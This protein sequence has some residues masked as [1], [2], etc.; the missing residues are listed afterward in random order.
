[1]TT[2]FNQHQLSL[3]QAA[4]FL[5]GGKAIFTIKSEVTGKHFTYKITRNKRADNEMYFVSLMTG[6]SNE[7]NYTFFATIFG[8]DNYRHGRKS[9]ISQD[10]QGTRAFRWFLNNL[11]TN[12]IRNQ[13]SVFHEG[14]CGCCGKRLT[15]PV[16]VELGFGPEC[17]KRMGL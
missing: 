11:K 9:T 5:F 14:R 17:S 3:E 4:S 7:A 15:T 6:P 16:S 2:L 13:V 10:A 1:M 12:T 8:K